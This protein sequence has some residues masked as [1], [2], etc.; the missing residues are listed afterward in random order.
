MKRPFPAHSCLSTFCSLTSAALLFS[1]LVVFCACENNNSSQT[2]D[3]DSGVPDESTETSSDSNHSQPSDT[4]SADS[5]TAESTYETLCDDYAVAVLDDG[6]AIHNNVW[7]YESSSFTGYSQCVFSDTVQSGVFGWEWHLEGESQFPSYPRVGFGWNPWSLESSGPEV[8]PRQIQSLSSL[9]ISFEKELQADGL[10]NTA[11]DV[12]VT[13]PDEIYSDTIVGEIM[14]W[15][16][17]TKTPSAQ[18]MEDDIAI[19]AQSYNFYKNTTWNDFPYLA[20]VQT[21]GE[22]SGQIDLMPFV[23]YLVANEHLPADAYIAE[24]EFGN[25][26]WSGNGTMVVQNFSVAV[27]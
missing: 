5:A 23:S 22:W 10:Y 27:E 2:R 18:L 9:A 21:S 4:D 16:D 1:G 7:G 14:V 26:I 19:G 3:S 15:L 12:W 17:G 24:V 25:E 8:L 13:A 6:F 11:F 20:F